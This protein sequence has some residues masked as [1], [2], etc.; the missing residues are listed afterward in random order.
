MTETKKVR[1]KKPVAT[2]TASKVTAKSTPVKAPTAK[3]LMTT[4]KVATTTKATKTTKPPAKATTTKTTTK[5]TRTPRTTKTA[6]KT[7]KTT[8][9]TVGSNN[10]T[11]EQATEQG[12]P[13]VAV[14]S[15]E[16]D[17]NNVGVGSFELDWNDKFLTQLIRSGY[18]GKDDAAIVDQWFN[19]VCRNVVMET[20]E[21]EQAN[22]PTYGSVIDIGNGRTSHS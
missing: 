7:K 16:I 17:S 18:R 4:A 5:T 6:A 10:L 14:L 11:K 22:N 13:W 20:Y 8:T 3:K 15:V 19:D 1:V 12:L 2:K 21:Q 9:T